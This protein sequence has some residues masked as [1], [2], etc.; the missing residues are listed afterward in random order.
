[1]PLKELWDLTID[2]TLSGL[3][4]VFGTMGL[5]RVINKIKDNRRKREFFKRNGCLLLLQQLVSSDEANYD[6]EKKHLFSL[7]ELH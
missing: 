2:I 6:P 7:N 1:M 5:N 3:V 4:L